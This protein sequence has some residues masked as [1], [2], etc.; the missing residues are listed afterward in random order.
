MHR[1]YGLLILITA[2]IALSSAYFGFMAFNASGLPLGVQVAGARA[3]LI[4]PVRGVPLPKGLDAGD[5]LDLAAQPRSTRM[6]IAQLN[7]NGQQ[8]PPGKVYGLTIRRG[9]TTAVYSV[10]SVNLAL[11]AT[12]KSPTRGQVKIPHV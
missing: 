8:V 5:R 4:V 2:I 1:R 12:S 6:A 7:S 11:A 9:P 10:G 3:G